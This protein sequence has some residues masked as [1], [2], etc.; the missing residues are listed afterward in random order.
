MGK[1]EILSK[2]Q[3]IE[4]HRLL[5]SSGNTML[6]SRRRLQFIND[7]VTFLNTTFTKELYHV[8]QWKQKIQ[9]SL[10]NEDGIFCYSRTLFIASNV[11]LTIKQ[12]LIKDNAIAYDLLPICHDIK[13]V[14]VP[15]N[16]NT[17]QNQ[18]TTT[19]R[20]IEHLATA[21]LYG[22]K[23]WCAKDTYDFYNKMVCTLENEQRFLYRQLTPFESKLLAWAR[24]ERKY[25]NEAMRKDGFKT[26]IHTI[27]SI[28]G[29]IEDGVRR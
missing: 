8:E 18:R 7:T 13:A 29:I 24:T 16:I 2:I 19:E 27:Y 5:N 14:P 22:L 10:Q 6:D 28:G 25:A 23:A 4:S 21:L 12:L 15:H 3:E 11:L 9:Q 17:K 26:T 20:I 1:D